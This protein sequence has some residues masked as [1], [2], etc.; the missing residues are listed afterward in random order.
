MRNS[1]LFIIVKIRYEIIS[2]EL[3]GVKYYAISCCTYSNNII[4]SCALRR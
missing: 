2:C 4:V 1:L 3:I